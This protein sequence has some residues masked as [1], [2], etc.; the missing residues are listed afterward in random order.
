[1]WI[2]S[3]AAFR[4]G[5]VGGSE[6][7]NANIGAY[8]IAVRGGYVCIHTDAPKATGPNSVA[9]G[10][11]TVASGYHSVAMGA[12]ITASA[13]YSIA[14]GYDVTN[15]K[16]A[17]FAVGYGFSNNNNYSLAVGKDDLDISLNANGDSLFQYS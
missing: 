13:S 17:F 7:D 1:M 8:S 3:E 6:W 15:S 10:E 9:F 4:T 5:K 12:V 14:M 16:Q 11:G 2:P